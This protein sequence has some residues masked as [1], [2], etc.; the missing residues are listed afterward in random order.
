MAGERLR[1]ATWNVHGLVGSDGRWGPDRVIDV[2]S[3]IG[4]DLVALQEVDARPCNGSDPHPLDVIA[5]NLD[6]TAVAGPTLGTPGN[7]YGNAVLSRFPIIEKHRHDLSR[8]GV[9]PR[10]AVDVRVRLDAR[11]LRFVAVHLGLRRAERVAQV[12]RLVADL[13]PLSEGADIVAVAGDLNAWWPRAR[14]ARIIERAVG[15]SPEPR[16]FPSRRPLFRLDRIFIRPLSAVVDWG[17]G[18]DARIRAASDHLPVWVDLEVNI[19][20]G[21][22]N[23]SF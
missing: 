8:P 16:T 19:E 20:Q 12:Q 10:G 1:L 22:S 13:Q 15:P 14:E 9:E 4:P 23:E 7:D 17:V 6:A 5:E 21:D 2:L 3:E 11:V 18:N